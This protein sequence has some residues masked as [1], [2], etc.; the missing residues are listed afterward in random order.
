MAIIK[1]DKDVR[2]SAEHITTHNGQRRKCHAVPTLQHFTDAVGAAYHEY[3]VFAI[4]EA[5]FFPDLVAFCT[6]AADN[7]RKHVVLAGL[8]GDFRRQPFGQV[9]LQ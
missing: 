7:H 3:D 8:D 9:G 1:S 6:A 2:Y 5:Q 4:D